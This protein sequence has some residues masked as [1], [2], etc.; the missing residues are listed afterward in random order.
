MWL[1]LVQIWRKFTKFA[2]SELQFFVIILQRQIF[3]HVQKPD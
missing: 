2:L 3:I 1:K